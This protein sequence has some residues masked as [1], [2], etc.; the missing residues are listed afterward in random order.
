VSNHP[1]EFDGPTYFTV[2]WMPPRAE[3]A[4]RVLDYC[5]SD[6]GALAARVARKTIYLLGIDPRSGLRI[7]PRVLLPWVV[8][9]AA[10]V[11][12]WRR[13]APVGRTELA[14]LWAWVALVNA[15][16]VVIYPWSYGWRLSAPSFIPL[17]VLCGVG[18]AAWAEAVQALRRG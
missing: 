8:A 7:V 11:F 10:S 13:R 5:L 6:P 1:P 14:L 3:I 4:G 12:L 15:P 2:K 9:A 16:L 17:Y 18:L